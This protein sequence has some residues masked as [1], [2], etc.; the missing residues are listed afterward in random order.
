MKTAGE[1]AAAELIDPLEA[2]PAMN[3]VCDKLGRND[4]VTAPP[5]GGC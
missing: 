1:A 2:V 4:G 3:E 5:D